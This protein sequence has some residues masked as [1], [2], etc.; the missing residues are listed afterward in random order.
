MPF[1]SSLSSP[2]FCAVASLCLSRFWHSRDLYESNWISMFSL[3]W[4]AEILL[5]FIFLEITRRCRINFYFLNDYKKYLRATVPLETV[6]LRCKP[7][8][9]LIPS[10]TGSNLP[11]LWSSWGIIFPLRKR[12]WQWRNLPWLPP[13]PCFSFQCRIS[14]PDPLPLLK[15]LFPW[16]VFQILSENFVSDTCCCAIWTPGNVQSSCF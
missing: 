9:P 7:R 10:A 5:L 13:A 8:K 3:P 12:V 6:E 4:A 11:S 2:H 15:N 14:T 16:A 1:S